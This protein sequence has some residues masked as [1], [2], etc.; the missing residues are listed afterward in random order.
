M[1]KDQLEIQ[2]K[3]LDPVII[4]VNIVKNKLKIKEQN[5]KDW[6]LQFVRKIKL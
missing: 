4:Y 2:N 5:K 1:L 6:L 3:T